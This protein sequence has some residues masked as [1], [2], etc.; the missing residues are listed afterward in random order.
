MASKIA[1]GPDIAFAKATVQFK[2]AFC[3]GGQRDKRPFVRISRR[4]LSTDMVKRY[5]LMVFE[6]PQQRVGVAYCTI[7]QAWEVSARGIHP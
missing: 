4:P 3:G 2:Y 1:T 6:P 7:K 5:S